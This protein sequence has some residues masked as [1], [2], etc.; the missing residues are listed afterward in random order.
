[1]LTNSES[2]FQNTR[3]IETG[4]SGHHKTYSK[5]KEPITI[6]Y[7][8][9]KNFDVSKYNNVLKQN[10]EQLNIETMSYEDFHKIFMT[11]LDKHAPDEEKNS[12]RK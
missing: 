3:T 4:L 7:R 12:E 6:T 9:Y 11:V 5:K 10:L 8:S 1:M 2:S